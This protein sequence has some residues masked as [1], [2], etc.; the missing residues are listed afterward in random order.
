MPFNDKAD[1]GTALLKIL[2]YVSSK[3]LVEES[4]AFPKCYCITS[5]DIS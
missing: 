5:K 4:S 2:L 3:G 1:T